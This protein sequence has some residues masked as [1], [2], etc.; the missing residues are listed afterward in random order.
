MGLPDIALQNQSKLTH[1]PPIQQKSLLIYSDACKYKTLGLFQSDIF[2]FSFTRATSAYQ[3]PL[4]ARP[5]G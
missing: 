5:Q 4:C 2:Y 1:A 3:M